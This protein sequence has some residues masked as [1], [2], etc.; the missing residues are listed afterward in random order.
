M[1]LNILSNSQKEILPF[2]S[3]FKREFILVGGTLKNIKEFGED[4]MKIIN[5]L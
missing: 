5:N 3:Q 1:Y 2:L 4:Y